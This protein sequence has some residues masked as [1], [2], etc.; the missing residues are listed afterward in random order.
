MANVRR[1]VRPTASEQTSGPKGVYTIVAVRLWEQLLN[2]WINR[3]PEFEI[4]GSA[5]SGVVAIAELERSDQSAAIVVI[6]AGGRFALE[7]ASV[8]RQSDA[9]KRLVAV[10]VDEDPGQA[11]AWA[12][13][14]ALGL[15]G[16]NASLDELDTTLSEVAAGQAHCSAGISGALVRGVGNNGAARLHRNGA[17]LT[18]RE[19][20]VARLAADGLTNHEIATRLQISPGTVKSHVHNVIRKL[21]VG[22]RAHISQKLVPDNPLRSVKK[23]G[24]EGEDTGP[25]NQTRK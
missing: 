9:A 8:I 23:S 12:A 13:T 22:R 1:T 16:R 11:V 25:Q 14:G 7:T 10:S 15:I 6:D 2:D 19:H 20:E 24:G 21:G 18:E 4:V 5:S 3:M 17:P